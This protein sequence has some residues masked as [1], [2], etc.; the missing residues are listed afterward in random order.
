MIKSSY[1]AGKAVLIFGVSRTGI[2]AIK[3]MIASGA[4]LVVSDDDTVKLEKIKEQLPNVTVASLKEVDWS[5]IKFL[6]LSPG[7]PLYAPITHPVVELAKKHNVEFIS[8]FDVLYMACPTANFIGVTGTNGKS[9]TTALI[10]HVLSACGEKVQVGGNIGISPLELIPQDDGYYVLE[11]SSYQLDLIE[12]MHL[13]TA[14]FI[15]IT[16]DHIDRHGTFQR[17][18]EAKAKIFKMLSTKGIGVASVDYKEAKNIADSA[19]IK[20]TFSTQ[21]KDADVYIKDRILVDNIKGLEFNFQ[22][23]KDLPGA[24]NEE[25]IA[26]AYAICVAQGLKPEEVVIAIKSFTGLKHRI[27][28]IFESPRYTF[29]NDSKA[30]NADAAEKALH[31]YEQ[32]YWIAGGIAKDG[33]IDSLLP[34]I[35]ERVRLTLLIGHAQ[36]QFA[37]VLTNLQ[38]PFIKC[39]TLENALNFLYEQANASG[40]VLLSPA[41]A[42]MDQFKDYEHRGDEFIRMVNE[43]FG[44]D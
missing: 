11:L 44:S 13:D 38:L 30:T 24:H 43:K 42:S 14:L 41:C 2:S 10:G 6:L 5:D 19:P 32:I 15:N 17:Y 21:N 22:T 7:V 25:N 4:N 3:S 23:Y 16:P 37:E 12:S 40:I 1:F 28:K 9:T 18:L 29:I 27:E 34:L 26:A 31:C 33:G 36:E 8:D 35:K 20:I 39:G